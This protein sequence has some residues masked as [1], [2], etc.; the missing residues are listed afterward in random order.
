MLIT[1]GVHTQEPTSHLRPR[2]ADVEREAGAHGGRE[3]LVHVLRAAHLKRLSA[4]CCGC[5]A[6]TLWQL[7]WEVA[8]ACGCKGLQLNIQQR[9]TAGVVLHGNIYKSVRLLRA[10]T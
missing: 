8:P 5:R 9:M 4:L 2:V 6:A 1:S 10:C 3:R 7:L